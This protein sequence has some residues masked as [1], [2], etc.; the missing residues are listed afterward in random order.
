MVPVLFRILCLLPN[1]GILKQSIE[2]LVSR[3]DDQRL[4]LEFAMTLDLDS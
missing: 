2:T 4:G 3:T 1:P